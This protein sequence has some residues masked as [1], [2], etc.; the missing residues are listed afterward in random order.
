MNYTSKDKPHPRGEICT[1]GNSLF[2]CYYKQDKETEEMIDKD[3]WLHSGD[4]GELNPKTGK[5]Y[6]KDRKK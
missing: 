2:K 5:L 1:R 4:I 3:G 6:V